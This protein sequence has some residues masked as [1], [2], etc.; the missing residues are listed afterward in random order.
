MKKITI[1]SK[2]YPI[3]CNALTYVKYR[4]KIQKGNI[5]R[6]KSFAIFFN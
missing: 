5:R 4:E 2:E 3:D 6:Y 1:C